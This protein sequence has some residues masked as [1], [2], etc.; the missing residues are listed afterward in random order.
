M[1]KNRVLK[2]CVGACVGALIGFGIDT[3]IK[4][5]SNK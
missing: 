1:K 2:M 5:R 3:I 4:Q